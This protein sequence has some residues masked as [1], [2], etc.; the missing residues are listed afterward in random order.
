MSNLKQAFFVLVNVAISLT[1]LN[2]M[3]NLQGKIYCPKAKFS[4]ARIPNGMRGFQDEINSRSVQPV[5]T[6]V[7]LS[8]RLLL[9]VFW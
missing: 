9:I 3:Q 6:L 4:I 8:H 1:L 7:R 5:L 2:S